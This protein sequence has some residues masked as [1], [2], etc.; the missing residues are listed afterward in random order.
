MMLQNLM[1]A[2]RYSANSILM[3]AT[4][5]PSSLKYVFLLCDPVT[6]TFDFLT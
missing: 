5:L 1:L 6:L 2:T 3:P 4:Q